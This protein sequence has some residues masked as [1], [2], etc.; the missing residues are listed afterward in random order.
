MLYPTELRGPDF[1]EDKKFSSAFQSPRLI[2]ALKWAGGGVCARNLLF[3]LRDLSSAIF[4]FPGVY[5][6][7]VGL[8][9][10][11]GEKRERKREKE[12]SE[13]KEREKKTKK[14]KDDFESHFD[15][16]SFLSLISPQSLSLLFSFSFNAMT[17]N[18][19]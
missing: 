4:V 16:S 19:R 1:Q 15:C 10:K 3:F 11:G 13:K 17:N 9:K 14:K 6:S 18:K 8:E 5:E 2:P 12:L 7:L